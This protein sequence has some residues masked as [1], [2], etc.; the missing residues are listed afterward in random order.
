MRTILTGL[1]VLSFGGIA[2]GQDVTLTSDYRPAYINEVNK[3]LSGPVIQGGGTVAFKN[4]CFFNIWGSKSLERVEGLDY[5]NEMNY[6]GGCGG[7][8]NDFGW[9]A[10]VNY[11]DIAPLF[12]V[13]G[14]AVQG[15]FGL[16]RAFAFGVHTVTPHLDARPTFPF[17]GPG[18][19][20]TEAGVDHDWKMHRAFSLMSGALIGYDTGA[21]DGIPS[22]YYRLGATP[23]VAL[24]PSLDLR[25]PVQYTERRNRSDF[26]IGIGLTFH[27]H[28]K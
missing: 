17:Q 4:G 18:G 26:T 23:I 19:P 28:V 3:R 20:R 6:A 24:T 15:I 27:P 5:G 8:V 2:N 21:F 7:R 25:I 9:K 11:L 16:N 10:A 1:L 12:S 13:Q 14:D 22:W